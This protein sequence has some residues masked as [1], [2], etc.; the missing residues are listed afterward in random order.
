MNL[1]NLKKLLNEKKISRKD[2]GLQ[3]G[4]TQNGITNYINGYRLPSIDILIKIANIFE[5]SIDYLIG[6]ENETGIIN[7]SNN[8][9]LDQYQIELLALFDTLSTKDKYRAIGIIQGLS[10]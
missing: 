9:K 8:Q 10:S 5:C 6:R 1:E 7:I 3:I 4:I 2:L